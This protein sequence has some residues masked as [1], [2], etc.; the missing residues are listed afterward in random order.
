MICVLVHE[1]GRLEQMRVEAGSEHAAMKGS[2]VEVGVIQGADA[3]LVARAHPQNDDPL[4]YW[5][6]CSWPLQRT[7]KGKI[8]AIPKDEAQDLSVIRLLRALPL[9]LLS[10]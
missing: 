3:V 10:T 8:L 2:V 5:S 1:D 9:C 4:H 6:L 7:V